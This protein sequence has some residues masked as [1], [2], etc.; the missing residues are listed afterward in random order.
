MGRIAMALGDWS[1]GPAPLQRKLADALRAAIDRGDL[2]PGSRLPAERT[3]A[4]ALAVSRSTVVAALEGLRE[5][6]VVVSRRGS[7]TRVAVDARRRLPPSDPSAAIRRNVVAEAFVERS[8]GGIEL[9]GAHVEALPSMTAEVF[10]D[11]MRDLGPWLGGSGY[12]PLGLPPLREAIAARYTARGVPTGA[13]EVLV[14]NGAQQGLALASALLVRHDDAVVLESPTYLTAIDLLRAAGARLHG[15]RSGADGVDVRALREAVVRHAPSLVY[16]M[17]TFHNPVGGVLPNA[18]RAVVAGLAAEHGF[19]LV[20]DE[21]LADLAITGEADPPPIA[22]WAGDATV[23]TLGSMSKVFWGG[24]RVGWVRAPAE[25]VRRLGR[26]K[27]VADIGSSLPSQAVAVRLL[28]GFAAA[29][30][31][32][33]ALIGA[34]CDALVGL[35]GHHLPTWSFEVPRGGLCLWVKLPCGDAAELAQVARRHG[36]SIVPGHLAAPEGG[37][38]DHLR[39]PLTLAPS[40][41]EE[42]VKRLAAA[43]GAYLPAAERRRTAIDVLV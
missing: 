42:G 20:D 2:A 27:A 13:D 18:E 35:L 15:V 34:S 6:G 10:A 24:L 38:G 1:S 17:P 39:L 8:A 16:L 36:V 19:V 40:V 7:G 37:L 14:T 32:R 23:L 11:A 22:R 25:V 12:V 31:E 3:L 9:L 41:L 30:E 26:L 29:R 4:Q 28:R 33:R 21:A 43:W 5:E